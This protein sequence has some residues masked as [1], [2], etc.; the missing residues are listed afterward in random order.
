MA[1]SSNPTTTPTPQ[2]TVD[3]TL[4]EIDRLR[5][6]NER[7]KAQQS[8][9]VGKLTVKR[10][11]PDGKTKGNALSVYGLGRYPVTLY[12]EQAEALCQPEVIAEILAMA[13]TLPRKAQR[14]ADVEAEAEGF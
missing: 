8:K 14:P 10:T 3:A 12:R 5:A 9:G 4:A 7:L 11:K 2:S 13:K 6:E 1:T